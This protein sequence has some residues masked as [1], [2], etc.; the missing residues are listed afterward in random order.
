[1]IGEVLSVEILRPGNAALVAANGWPCS[2]PGC[3]E[4]VTVE[5]RFTRRT[6][7]NPGYSVGCHGTCDA[8]AED[9]ARSLKNDYATA[10][11]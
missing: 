8:H 4:K 1:M 5:V 10:E 7:G 6:R 11:G 2:R 3:P 9:H